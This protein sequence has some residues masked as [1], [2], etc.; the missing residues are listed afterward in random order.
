[1]ALRQLLSEAQIQARIREIGA[2]IDA[3][4]PTGTLYLICILKGACYFM[5]DLSRAIKR[6]TLID[7]IGIST[8]RSKA[9]TC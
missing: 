3:D 4:Y 5:A 1:L 7:F 8:S 9:R 6:D 2:R